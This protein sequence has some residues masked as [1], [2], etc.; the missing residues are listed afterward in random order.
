MLGNQTGSRIELLD[1]L[2]ADQIAAGEVVER[3]AS[4][5][6]ELLENSIDAGADEIRVQ[7]DQGGIKRIRV[8]DNGC[9]IAREDLALAISRHATSKIR[10]AEDLEDIAT[11]GFRG[12]ALASVAS[13]S[14]M[15]ITSRRSDSEHAWSL[16]C[17]SH[18]SSERHKEAR[19]AIHSSGTTVEVLDLFYNIPA[20][21]KFLKTERTETAHLEKIFVR[22]AL[23]HF[24]ISFELQQGN[25]V[26]HRLQKAHTD[27]EKQRRLSL[28]LSKDFTQRSVV[29]DERREGLRLSGWVG[30]PT[31][32]RSQSDR[33]YFYVN[34][35]AIQDKLV[36]HAVRQAYRDVLFH[37]RHPVFLLY[38]DIDPRQVDVNVHP[39]KHEVRFRDSRSVHDFI[40]ATLNRTLREL[41]PDDGDSFQVAASMTGD[42]EQREARQSSMAWTGPSNGYPL[43]QPNSYASGGMLSGSQLLY[44]VAAGEGAEFQS[45]PGT[46]D[47]EIP[48]LG[49]ALAQLHGIY[50][51]AQNSE[52][53]VLVDMHAAHERIVYE[54]LKA[55]RD[56]H[57]GNSQRLLVPVEL[58]VTPQEADLARE[59]G[60]ALAGLGLVLE[61]GPDTTLRVKAVPHL[62]A[63]SD[64]EQLVRDLLSDLETHGAS[65]VN[66]RIETRQDELLASMACHASVRAHR[67]LS[68]AEMNALLR[69]MEQTENAG[70]CNHGRPTYLLRSLKDLDALFLRGQ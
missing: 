14:R 13:V 17:A 22:M 60:P 5:I 55:Q 35:R 69:E 36:A 44:Q 26:M 50:V 48:P 33:Q 42:P 25:Q 53:L 68:I 20:R 47:G 62:L 15:T 8:T 43:H 2:V 40:F 29:I 6:K 28:L 19:P 38:L 46:G 37:G 31:F 18:N 64:A 49:Y 58:H 27:V 9:G 57:S 10:R 23:S 32:S 12:E 24:N 39:T 61:S 41:R 7:I 21:R 67:A 54:K 52:G 3:P 45:L 16:E 51:L 56:S 11:L 30:L 63:D 34:E 4:I 59:A 65:G 1:P 66:E 70:Q